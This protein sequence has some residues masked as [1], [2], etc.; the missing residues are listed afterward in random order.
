MKH[1]PDTD[2]LLDIQGV[3]FMVP[4]VNANNFFHNWNIFILLFE[5]S[6]VKSAILSG[7]KKHY[8]TLFFK[9]AIVIFLTPVIFPSQ[10]WHKEKYWMKLHDSIPCITL[11]M[12]AQKLI[13]VHTSYFQI[14]VLTPWEWYMRSMNEIE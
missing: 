4:K 7:I 1:T 2:I 8:S 11:F 9:D 10:A 3:F 14:F 6:S 12:I 5:T 13:V